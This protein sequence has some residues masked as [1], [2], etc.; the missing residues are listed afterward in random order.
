V[1]VVVVVV[2]ACRK[3]LGLR[4]VEK[5]AL[6][7]VQSM[8]ED[9]GVYL[10]FH[11]Q[12][13]R[14]SKSTCFRWLVRMGFASRV[15]KHRRPNSVAELMS[16]LAR[17]LHWLR[18]GPLAEPIPEVWGVGDSMF[19]LP[20]GVTEVIGMAARKRRAG[21]QIP[22]LRWQPTKNEDF[23]KYPPKF[24]W[25]MDQVPFHLDMLPRRS[26]ADLEEGG[27]AHVSAQPAVS[28]RFGTLCVMMHG[29]EME[30]PKLGMFFRGSRTGTIYANESYLYHPSTRVFLQPSAWADEPTMLDWAEAVLKPFADAHVPEDREYILFADNLTCHRSQG[31]RDKVHASRGRLI[32]GPANMTEIWQ[33]VDCGHAGQ[34]IKDTCSGSFQPP[35]PHRNS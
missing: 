20:E 30:Q 8:K 10:Q 21:S 29:A 3:P 25:N 2:L 32:F 28:K 5:L 31:F 7:I 12:D 9:L 11:G 22:K 18:R 13:F 1:V 17:Y 15:S 33:P 34:T 19:Q 6:E 16:S 24:R 4:L 26:Y 14:C 35:P 23:G 27:T